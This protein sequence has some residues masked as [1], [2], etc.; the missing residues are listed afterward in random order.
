VI[1]PTP[2]ASWTV[3]GTIDFPANESAT[4]LKLVATADILKNDASAF[5]S[6][7]VALV[8]SGSPPT[9]TFTLAVDPTRPAAPTASISLELWNDADDDGVHDVL[10][11]RRGTDAAPG[12]TVWCD[13]N[14]CSHLALFSRLADGARGYSS[15]YGDWEITITGWYTYGSCGMQAC[16]QLI[17]GPFTGARLKYD[18]YNTGAITPGP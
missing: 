18:E 17:T 5:A 3:S 8:L 6:D 13:A 1:P 14:G 9:A 12:S 16:A 2:A 11:A 15:V 10:E 4:K 7:P